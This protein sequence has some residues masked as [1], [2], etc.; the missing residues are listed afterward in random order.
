M[1]VGDTA[2][3]TVDSVA[4]G[5]HCVA[6]L[7]GQVLFVRHA[8]PG[9]TVRVHITEV[10][11]RGRYL[12]ADCTDVLTAS[13][14]RVQPPC[15]AAGEC[16]GCDWQHAAL[17]LQRRLKR[18]VLTQA[19][20]DVVPP[21]LLDSLV[22]EEVPGAPDGL[23]WRTRT[24]FRVDA[25]G[26]PGLLRHR[27]HE[28]VVLDECPIT[29]S[30]REVLARPWPGASEVLLVSTDQVVALADPQP[31]QVRVHQQARGRQWRVDAAGFWQVHPG[32]AETLASC[33]YELAGLRGG[34]RVLDLYSGVGLFAGSLAA[35]VGPE[36]TITAV[37]A[38]GEACRNAR[39][40]LHDLPWVRIENEDVRRWLRAATPSADIVILDPPRAGA[41][42]AVVRAI[43]AMH[44]DRVVYVSCDPMTLARDLRTFSESGYD[45]RRLRAFDCFPM[46]HHMETVVCLEPSDQPNR[47]LT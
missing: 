17:P 24:R 40:N 7:D 4:H 5:G 9:E 15:R 33:V 27:S 12:R 34:E 31:R 35:E 20:R 32:A 47:P 39:R 16:G 14:D 43:A 26:R 3:V 25:A 2:T 30:S 21:D 8:L 18:E 37:E 22:V 38:D 44:P 11:P 28:L 36:V 41:G 45:V 29:C 1:K 6:R 10:G 42:P 46:T 19:L 23:H 13:P